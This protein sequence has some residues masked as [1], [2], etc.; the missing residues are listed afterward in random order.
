MSA[1]RDIYRKDDVSTK[2]LHYAQQFSPTA[3]FSLDISHDV[4]IPI[5]SAA[6]LQRHKRHVNANACQ[7]IPKSQI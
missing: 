7:N 5:V 2:R 6:N 4:S 1:I 3:T